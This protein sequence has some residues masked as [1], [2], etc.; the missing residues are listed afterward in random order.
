MEMVAV[1][2]S[3][4]SSAFG[5]GFLIPTYLEMKRIEVSLRKAIKDFEEIA[6]A[7][8]HA[9]N[10]VTAKILQLEEKISTL[11][12]WKMSSTGFKK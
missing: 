2:F 3:V 8:S 4:V 11:D 12:F 6:Q 9:N 5:I 10:S 7:A 1:L